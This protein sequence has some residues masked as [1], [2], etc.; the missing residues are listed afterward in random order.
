[1]RLNLPRKT[2]LQYNVW[3]EYLMILMLYH[4]KPLNLID[5]KEIYLI[6]NW[7]I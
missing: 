6:T 7:Q 3:V 2:D 4:T 1:M 5:T